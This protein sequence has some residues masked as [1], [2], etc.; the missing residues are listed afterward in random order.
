VLCAEPHADFRSTYPH[1]RADTKPPSPSTSIFSLSFRSLCIT[2]Q[3]YYSIN[4]HI[5]LIYFIFIA[6]HLKTKIYDIWY[7]IP[8]P[9]VLPVQLHDLNSDLRDR[10]ALIICNSPYFQPTI[11]IVIPMLSS[12]RYHLPDNSVASIVVSIYK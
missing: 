11:Y 1:A 2:S 5:N 3:K 7:S 8:Y 9:E 6:L 10:C 12:R 4:S